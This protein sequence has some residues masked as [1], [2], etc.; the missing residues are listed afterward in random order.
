MTSFTETIK[1]LG[2]RRKHE[3]LQDFDTENTASRA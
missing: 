3:V 1:Y 2:Y